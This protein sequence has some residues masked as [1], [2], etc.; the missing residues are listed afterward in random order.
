M[1]V[2][3][4]AAGGGTFNVGSTWVGGVAPANGDSIVVNGSSGNLTLSANSTGLIGADF[5]GYTG[6]LTLNA[7]SLTFT[8]AGGIIVILSPNMTIISTTGS[9]NITQATTITSNGKIF[10][11]R[12][13][14]AAVITLVGTATV[15]LLA[16]AVGSIR[17]ADLII[18][19]NSPGSMTQLTIQPGYKVIYRPTGTLTISNPVGIGHFVIDTLGTISLGGQLSMVPVTPG[20]PISSTLEF[21]KTAIWTGAGT[22]AG[23]PNLLCNATN[24]SLIGSTFSIIMTANNSLNDLSIITPNNN[25]INLSLTNKLISNSI[26]FKSQT[27]ASGT[28]GTVNVLGDGGFSA[29]NVTIESDKNFNLQYASTVVKL[30]SDGTYS[31]TYL[32]TSGY[33]AGPSGLSVSYCI[34]SSY[35]AS[36][37]AIM[38]ITNGA[39]SY[40]EIT[41]IDNSAGTLQ[42]A[43]TQNGNT[44]TRTSGFTS[45]TGGTGSGGGGG[46]FTFVS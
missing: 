16:N 21:T 8:I 46:S 11:I 20:T 27:G 18:A 41:D 7:F 29:S 14:S 38:E 42:Y 26:L 19:D 28:R 34:L 44:L 30:S 6:T 43:I 5:T 39:Y 24:T 22:V 31:A 37:P 2:K 25:Y 1:A 4:V 32:Y 36:T 9:F 45:T 13:S 33:V 17:G 12:I 35:T 23:K 10:P 15:S 3:T 40:T